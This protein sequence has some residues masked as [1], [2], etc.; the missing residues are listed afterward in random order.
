VGFCSSARLPAGHAIP[1]SVTYGYRKGAD[2]RAISGAARSYAVGLRHIL[3]ILSALALAA[4]IVPAATA[5]AN[6][7]RTEF[8]VTLKAPSLAT[9]IAQSRVLSARVRHSRLDVRSPTSVS[10]VRGLAAQQRALERRVA[11]AFPD[12]GVRWRYHVVLDGV[13]V[14]ATRRDAARLA[15][16]PGVA[17]VYPA[18]RYHA[19]ERQGY[20]VIGAPALWGPSL[21][22]AGQGIKIGIIDDGV[23]RTHRY[24]RPAGLPMPRGFPK[25]N[26]RYTTA[27]VIVA[28]AFAPPHAKWRYAHLPFDPLL[29]EHGT[30]VAGIAAGDYHT[31]AD[32]TLI[33]GVAPKAYLGPPRP[34]S[35]RTGTRPRSSPASR[36]P[37]A[38]GWT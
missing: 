36:P 1:V 14:V 35:A 38:T 33:S 26:Q 19:L 22:T 27:K 5:G 16:L 32:G 23:D 6:T 12:A 30:H 8:L 11:T 10:Y 28:R 24:L 7:G 21:T 20:Q 13:S 15:Q 4:A 17:H 9:A 34:G 37:C 31:N 2:F 18:V 29:S 3:V 25:G